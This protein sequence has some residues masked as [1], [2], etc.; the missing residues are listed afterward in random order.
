MRPVHQD[1]LMLAVQLNAAFSGYGWA[2][3]Q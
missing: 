1:N 2:R 3:K